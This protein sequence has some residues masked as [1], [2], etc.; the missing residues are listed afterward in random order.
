M[1]PADFVF[2]HEALAAKELEALINDSAVHFGDPQFGCR[3]CVRRQ[4]TPGM[5]AKA[6][7]GVGPAHRKVRLEISKLES[8]VLKRADRRSERTA[9]SHIISCQVEGLLRCRD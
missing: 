8:G 7:V 6:L 1:Q 9:L 5:F 2:A 3:G 4:F